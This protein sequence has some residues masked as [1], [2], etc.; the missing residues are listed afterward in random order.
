MDRQVSLDTV[1]DN[2]ASYRTRHATTR[3]GRFDA[4]LDDHSYQTNPPPLGQSS[5]H[6]TWMVCRG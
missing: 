5:R 6:G 1:F 2:P 4:R 3:L